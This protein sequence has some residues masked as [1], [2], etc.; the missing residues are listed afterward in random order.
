MYGVRGS[1]ATPGVETVKYGG[2]TACVFVEL[3]DGTKLIFDAGTGIRTLGDSLKDGSDDLYLFFSHFHWDHIQGIPFFQPAYQQDRK[4]HFISNYIEED[5]LSVLDQMVDPHFPVPRNRLPATIKTLL[6]DKE[7]KLSMGGA[8]ISSCALNHPGGGAA[9]RVDT[10]QGSM[11]YITD[12]ELIPPYKPNTTFDE[13][14]T[15]IKGVDLLIHDAM[16]LD[17]E[18]D[19]IHGWGHSLISQTMELA[20]KADIP[21]LVLFHHD[22]LRTDKQLDCILTDCQKELKKEATTRQVSIATEG[23]HYE[24]THAGV[25]HL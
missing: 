17:E 16:Y 23:E 3:K 4:L 19:K 18:A 11:A 22:P 5:S 2:N 24:I 12:N 8:T 13:W 20:K 25:K 7:G 14:V 6:M 9:Y 21:H 15:F 1:I 10:L